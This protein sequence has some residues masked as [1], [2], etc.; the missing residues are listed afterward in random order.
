M[1][2]LLKLV[3]LLEQTQESKEYESVDFFGRKNHLEALNKEFYSPN[4]WG[5]HW[6]VYGVRRSGKT[7]LIRH[8]IRQKEKQI[9]EQG[10]YSFSYLVV[11]D[12]EVSS[13]ENAD[14]ASL[15]LKYSVKDYLSEQGKEDL[16]VV[17]EKGLW[18]TTEIPHW[19]LFF[20]NLAFT[21][22]FLKEKISQQ[23]K[24][25]CFF[26]EIS[27]FSAK[28]D[29]VNGYGFFVNQSKYN[30]TNTMSFLACS[31][32]SWMRS[33]IFKNTTNL[34]SRFRRI[35]VE[36]FSFAEVKDFFLHS[37]WI[38]DEKE[39][40]Q[41]YLLFG[42]F[43]KF[44]KESGMN[45][46]L[47]FEDNINQLK[48]LSYYLREEYDVFFRGIFSE[49]KLH[50]EIVAKILEKRVVDFEQLVKGVAEEYKRKEDT[51][52]R[53]IIELEYCGVLK[54]TSFL[55][56]E[57][58]YC[59][60]P[61]FYLYHFFQK[62]SEV[63]FKETYHNWRG[64]MF[65]LYVYDNLKD[66]LVKLGIKDKF[67]SKINFTLKKKDLGDG[68]SDKIVAQFD[69]IAEVKGRFWRADRKRNFVL[70]ELKFHD[71]SLLTLKQLDEFQIKSQIM[72]LYLSNQL[73]PNKKVEKG[74][75]EA[76][77]YFVT[78]NQTGKQI[79][80]IFDLI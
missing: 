43:V 71:K 30:L 80:N 52:I 29:F 24:I 68:E 17:Y 26:D 39:I 2:E 44:Y 4:H 1:S 51:I 65:E 48:V 3:D 18:N 79:Y 40:L 64:G 61:H 23:L 6:G 35:H 72:G 45:L 63:D 38:K 77:F 12:R 55:N 7:T 53:Q 21:I 37:G 36:P 32:N 22:S 16:F 66:I 54:R 73:F 76:E 46:S 57:Q 34:Y 25:F 11:G 49:N 8:F 41:Y 20:E 10:G 56:K 75:V 14:K 31:S 50:R 59:C 28:N 70:I 42:G 19:E 13:K 60:L 74:S 47:P 62:N 33:K 27:W 5:S 69:I 9:K 67:D 58:V 78:T 15:R